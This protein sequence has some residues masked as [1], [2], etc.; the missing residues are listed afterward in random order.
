MILIAGP[1]EA[2]DGAKHATSLI[3]P[4][5]ASTLLE[6]NLNLGL[7]VQQGCHYIACSGGSE[8]LRDFAS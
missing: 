5:D 7:I 1:E 8:N 3:T 2:R 4:R 6:G